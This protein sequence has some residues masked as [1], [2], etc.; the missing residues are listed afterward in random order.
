MRREGLSLCNGGTDVCAVENVDY[1][2]VFDGLSKKSVE[3]ADTG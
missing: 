2:C 1:V 3:C